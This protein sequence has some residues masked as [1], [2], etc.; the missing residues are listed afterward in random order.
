MYTTESFPPQIRRLTQLVTLDIGHNPL[1][2]ANLRTL[3]ALTKLK[4]IEMCNIGRTVSNMPELQSLESLE[5]VDLAQNALTAIPS[6]L[7]MLDRLQTL[8]LANNSI[9]SF[10]L[11]TD[12]V[13]WP[14]LRLLD[15]SSNALKQ[16]PDNIGSLER[17]QKLFLAD[18]AL[19]GS[20][21]PESIGQLQYLHTLR[22]D[23]NPLGS[24]SEVTC[25]SFRALRALH[26]QSTDLT[27]LPV[28]I[29]D[30]WENL[31]VLDV[32]GNSGLKM[33]RKVASEDRF[34]LVDFSRAGNVSANQIDDEEAVVEERACVVT[35]Q[36]KRTDS[37]RAIEKQVPDKVGSK[38]KAL[39]LKLNGHKAQTP[40]PHPNLP[41]TED[42]E[43]VNSSNNA[44]SA[45]NKALGNSKD[46]RVCSDKLAILTREDGRQRMQIDCAALFADEE[47]STVKL[48][49]ECG[50]R[51]WAIDNFTPLASDESLYGG[52]YQGDAYIL[53]HTYEK[54]TKGDL[55]YDIWYWVGSTAKVDKAACV[56]IHS[57]MSI[58]RGDHCGELIAH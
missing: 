21:L 55:D 11:P 51:C 14:L 19:V 12:S 43:D 48:G 5:V 37:K 28:I 27:S 29:Y 31:H 56:A 3:C 15:L 36:T 42:R 41:S 26:L 23:F 20:M 53:L 40:I 38:G 6:C 52:F 39:Q 34:Y 45:V 16:L 32:S 7:Y 18:N 25:E 47:G 8:G 10:H 13:V 1:G 44:S 24:L 17:L 33:P 35:L 49:Q 58:H 57:G 4:T 50:V 46:A 9:T 54:S 22:L 30:V 2:Y